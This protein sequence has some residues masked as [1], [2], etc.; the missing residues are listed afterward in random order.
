M[1]VVDYE[2]IGV[3]SAVGAMR[4]IVQPD[5][6]GLAISFGKEAWLSIVPTL[7]D[8]QRDTIQV[9]AGVTGHDV[10][11]RWAIGQLAVIR[12]WP[13]LFSTMRRMLHVGHTPG[14]LQRYRGCISAR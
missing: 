8:V 10:I 2:H 14:P 11:D 1:D 3:Q 13:L 9:E 6:I 7:H 4:G 5:Q 12:T